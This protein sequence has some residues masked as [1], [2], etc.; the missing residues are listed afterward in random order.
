VRAPAE[1]GQLWLRLLDQPAHAATAGAAA[2]SVVREG[3]DVVDRTIAL[4]E[5][6]LRSES[7]EGS[8]A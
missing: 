7:C 6:Y 1:L 2:R 3:T 5:P 4:L 8:G